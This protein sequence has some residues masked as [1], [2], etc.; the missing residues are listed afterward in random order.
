MSFPKQV[1][2]TPLCMMETL[3]TRVFNLLTN[4]GYHTIGDVLRGHQGRLWMIREIAEARMA[5][6]NTALTEHLQTLAESMA[7][8]HA[9]AA[10]EAPDTDPP[11]I[12]DPVLP[13]TE[14]AADARRTGG[15][16][17]DFTSKPFVRW[18][19]DV[20]E[21]WPAPWPELARKRVFSLWRR[22]NETT[23]AK[24][25]GLTVRM[26]RRMEQVLWNGIPYMHALAEF[27]DVRIARA[28]RGRTTPLSTF[29]LERRDPW[30]QG[31][32]QEPGILQGALAG[33]RGSHFLQV[34]HPVIASIGDLRAS[35]LELMELLE[36]A[37]GDE[38]EEDEEEAPEPPSPRTK[39]PNFR[40]PPP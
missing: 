8:A 39:T 34:E 35:R 10:P 16:S 25:L 3:P 27:A 26:M 33:C 24:S 1:L 14:A 19:L 12:A 6:W 18:I 2:D 30:F 29:A 31:I 17:P 40:A 36:S 4:H 7:T 5:E 9:D 21:S 28:R 20:V 38:F 37:E 11:D 23:D 15:R 32:T 22:A 13:E